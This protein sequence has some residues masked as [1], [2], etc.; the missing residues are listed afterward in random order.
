VIYVICAVIIFAAIVLFGSFSRRNLY[1]EIDRLEAWK[2]DIT[3]RPVTEELAK[4]KGLNM[5]GET[6]EKFEK[7]RHDWDELVTTRLPALEEKLFEAE[8]AVDKFHFRKAKVI[9]NNLERELQ[10]I[11][12]IISLILKEVNELV[13]SE[14]QNRKEIEEVKKVY[15]D[16]R[17]Y[18]LAHH[19]TLGRT[20][21]QFEKRLVE[22]YQQILK[23]DELTQHGNH[24]EA[25][26][27]L[28]GVQEELTVLSGKLEHLPELLVQLQTK[29]TSQLEELQAGMI[30]MESNG[31]VLDHLRV[32]EEI[33][34]IHE[35][36][37]EELK[38]IAEVSIDETKQHVEEL[39]SKIEAIYYA[40]ENEVEAR[41]SI[42]S[43]QINLEK[44][45]T[46]ITQDIEQLKEETTSVQL[47]YRIEEKNLK[48]QYELEKGL[49]KVMSKFEVVKDA[50]RKQK[51]AYS[52]IAEMIKEIEDQIESLQ[53]FYKDYQKML[54]TLRKDELHAKETIH[55]LK[56][57]LFEAKKLVKQN[58]LPGLPEYYLNGIEA[59]EE[60]IMEVHEKLNES[61]LDIVSINYSLKAALDTVDDSVQQSSKLIEQTIMA[62]KL[63]TYGNRYRSRYPFVADQLDKAEREFRNYHYEEALKTAAEAVQKI[64]PQALQK[65]E[66]EEKIGV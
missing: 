32:E 11:E 16:T 30:E 21:I 54:H 4:L 43:K 40:L 36:V 35:K 26:A 41:N 7:W 47:N 2:I 33:E 25:R 12:D 66:I 55:L 44:N 56:K 64:E 9:L 52:T 28:L 29:I 45:I 27:V 34:E 46:H 5:V 50:Y 23:F 20:S 53:S 51:Q 62:E 8:E 61:P 3:N 24:L 59:A 37:E 31:Y 10:Q 17:Q 65:I 60:R 6:E 38:Q 49:N 22:V 39:F 1:K 48:A 15:R 18:I 42:I 13:V 63:I 19:R 57:K 58:N 14:E